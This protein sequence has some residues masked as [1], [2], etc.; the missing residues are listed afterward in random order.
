M[1]C[2]YWFFNYQF[3]FQDS[4]WNGCHYLT[5]LTV[6]VNGIAIITIKNVYYS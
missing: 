5:I 3:K 6:A 1:I 2:Y 4:V